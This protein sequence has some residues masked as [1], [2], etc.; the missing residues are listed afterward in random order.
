LSPKRVVC[1]AL[2]TLS[3]CTPW[4]D[5]ANLD[6][7]DSEAKEALCNYQYD[8]LGGQEFNKFCVANE[9]GA[10][11]PIYVGQGPR[12]DEVERCIADADTQRWLPC[13]VK[14]FV[15]CADA[16]DAAGDPCVSQ[17]ASEC[18]ALALCLSE[19]KRAA[20]ELEGE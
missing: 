12:D 19:A 8:A 18:E 15:E 6:T 4:D 20:E 9:D 16:A 11:V 10:N 1:A 13:P 7:L 14:M 5:A 2:L 3:A 17:T